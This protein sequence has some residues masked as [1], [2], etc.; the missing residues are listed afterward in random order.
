[1]HTL[2]SPKAPI[3]TPKDPVP[4]PKAPIPGSKVPIPVPKAPMPRKKP[5]NSAVSISKQDVNPPQA[6]EKSNTQTIYRYM[7]KM[8]KLLPLMDSDRV[9]ASI[10]MPQKIVNYD[11]EISIWRDDVEM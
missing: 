8:S 2:S 10:S 5:N 11:H 9:I 7:K 4:T 1:M 3:P 6:F